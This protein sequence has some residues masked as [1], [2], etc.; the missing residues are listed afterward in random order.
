MPNSNP[1]VSFCTFVVFVCLLNHA[2]A[3]VRRWVHWGQYIDQLCKLGG[4]LHETLVAACFFTSNIKTLGVKAFIHL[5][6]LSTLI[7]S[8]TITW[9]SHI[10]LF[11]SSL[12]N[13]HMKHVA[14]QSWLKLQ[15]MGAAALDLF[16][17]ETHNFSQP[18]Q[19]Q[20]GSV[21]WPS[22]W[23]R[24]L[25][26]PSTSCQCFRSLVCGSLWGGGIVLVNRKEQ[27][28]G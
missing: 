10:H 15:C 18:R 20:L 7:S 12:R 26:M 9:L 24:Y 3:L 17:S 22:R 5:L 11:Q 8:L 21:H 4:K 19:Q 25:T 16:I 14:Q 23:V 13:F 2:I 6:Q 1:T 28:A 27:E